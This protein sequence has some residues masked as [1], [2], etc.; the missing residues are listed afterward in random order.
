LKSGEQVAFNK[1]TRT[2]TVTLEGDLFDPS[3]LLLLLSLRDFLPVSYAHLTCP[4]VLF[5]VALAPN[6]VPFSLNFLR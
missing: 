4:Q 3:G 2:R 6:P 5:A 1:D